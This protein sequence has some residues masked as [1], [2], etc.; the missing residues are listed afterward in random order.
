MKDA[1]LDVLK[2]RAAGAM[3][4]IHAKRI[5]ICIPGNHNLHGQFEGLNK[6]IRNGKT[7][8][9]PGDHVK[10]L[11][12]GETGLCEI[13]D[14]P[15]NRERLKFLSTP[16]EETRT[17]VEILP[18]GDR[19]ETPFKAMKPAMYEVIDDQVKQKMAG[20][21]LETA[22]ESMSPEKLI[23][24]MQKKGLVLSQAAAPMPVQETVVA[25]LTSPITVNEETLA[26]VEEPELKPVK[27]KSRNKSSKDVLKAIAANDTN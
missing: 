7:V 23:E 4:I 17:R 5:D 15:F 16:I 21:M 10:V 3:P 14:T 13:P 26:K 18:N 24:I 22:M 1:Y 9:E 12:E 6:A 8:W 27:K 25:P 20:G 2:P 11:I 19:K